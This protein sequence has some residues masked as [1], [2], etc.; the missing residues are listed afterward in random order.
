METATI[1]ATTPAVISAANNPTLP[2]PLLSI[3]DYIQ[4]L[5]AGVTLFAALVALF[6]E[7][8]WRWIE[9][10]KIDVHFDIKDTECY[11][12]T[13]MH[14][15]T[16]DGGIISIPSYYIRLRI[17]NTGA[18]TM[19]NAEVVLEKV[20]PKP[21]KFMSLNLSWAG[22]SNPPG[23]ITRTV[24]IPTKKSRVVDIIEVMEPSQTASIADKMKQG[25][26]FMHERY[27]LYSNG[28]RSCSIMPNTLSDIFSAGKYVLHIGV[29][30]DNTEPKTIKL[31]IQYDGSWGA[32]GVTGMRN[33]HL[34]VKLLDS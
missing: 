2:P 6:A 16:S 5:I 29:Y 12:S 30:A 15:T 26:N 22:F 19:E 8:F 11:H 27:S 34:K 33:K 20:E 21:D 3:P 4:L 24:R 31:S 7:R 9:R 10:P 28:F 1:S 14:L 23:D 13:N 17:T 25:N 18:S 32:E